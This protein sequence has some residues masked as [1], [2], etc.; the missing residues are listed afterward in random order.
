M[1][2]T[3]LTSTLSLL[4]APRTQEVVIVMSV[5]F[6]T[7]IRPILFNMLSD[8]H[9]KNKNAEIWAQAGVSVNF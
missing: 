8:G 9:L 3:L 4:R 1:P 7:L 2:P 5:T 6:L